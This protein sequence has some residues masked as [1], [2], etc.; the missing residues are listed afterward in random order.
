MLLGSAETKAAQDLQPGNI[1]K[2]VVCNNSLDQS[3]AL[4]LPST[5][6]PARKWPLLAAFDPGARGSVPL[7]HFKQAAERYG[8]IVCGSNNSRNGPMAVSADA[9]YAMLG[10]VVNRFPIDEKRVYL[11]GFSGG[12][13]VAT[14]IAMLLKGRIAGVIEF[15]KKASFLKDSK[16]VKQSLAK[17]RD[18]EAEPG[19]KKIVEGLKQGSRQ[20]AKDREKR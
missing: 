1:I 11:T 6:S 15:E 12:A 16:A 4:Y 10:D 2:R 5:Y 17:D 14:T 18:Q 19:F 7:E 8:Y 3:Y 9:A 13:R 20:D